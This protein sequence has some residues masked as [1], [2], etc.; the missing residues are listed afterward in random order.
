MATVWYVVIAEYI[1]SGLGKTGL[2]D[3]TFDVDE[4]D[5][6]TQARAN[7]LTDQAATE[8]RN[9]HYFAFFEGDSAKIY[10]AT[11]V[12]ADSS[13]T[14]KQVS[15]LVILAE[16]LGS[17]DALISSRLAA[18]SYAAPPSAADNA[19]AAAGAILATPA[20]KLA[21]DASGRVSISGTKTTLDALADVSAQGVRDA[22][23]LAPS[24]GAPAAGSVDKHLDDLAAAAGGG[25]TAQ[26]YTVYG[27]DG[28]TP[29]PGVLCWLTT[30]SGGSNLV[31]SGTTNALGVVTF[32]HDLASGTT[33]YVWRYK[34]GIAYVNPDTEVIP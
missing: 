23:K 27:A 18:A 32:Y 19:S 28:V 34:A 3:V 5:P 21:T 1:T 9:G 33:V 11:A 16:R 4:Y 7:H 26:P 8:G 12:T 31:S 22:M 25:A 10:I 30:D 20:Q 17:V 13:V 14:Q 15:A 6:A 29:E 2:L 24:A